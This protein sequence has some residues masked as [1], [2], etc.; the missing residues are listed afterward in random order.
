MKKRIMSMILALVLLICTIPVS[1]ANGG[2]EITVYLSLSKYGSVVESAEG[3]P[4][5]YV[6]VKLSDKDCYNLDDCFKMAHRE[7]YPDGEEGY[8][9]SVGDW[10]LGIDMLWGD[11]SYNFGYQVNRGTESVMGLDHQL[12]DGDFID[13]CIYQN[14]YPDTEGYSRFDEQVKNIFLGEEITLELT[15]ASG[16]DENWNTIYSV[17]DSADILINGEVTELATN[18]NGQIT[19]SFDEPGKYIVSAQK[20]KLLID[21]TVPAIT[22]PVCVVNVTHPATRLVHGIAKM[23]TESDLAALGGNLSWILADMAVYADLFPGSEN[24]LSGEKKQEAVHLLVD[25]AKEAET[26]GDLAKA[27]LAFRSLGYDPSKIYTET[28]EHIDVVEKL[29]TLVENGDVAVTNVYT[30]PYVIIALSQTETDL[31]ES[32]VSAA[33]LIKQEWQ[34]MS[35]GTDALTPMISALAPYA[36]SNLEVLTA[37]EESV[38]IVKGEQREDG[39]IDGFEGYEAASTAL[40]IW[41]LSETG[42]D[43]DAVICGEN[44]LIDGLLSVSSEENNGF[45]NA[46]ATEQGFRGLLAWHLLKNEI[47]RDLYDFSNCSEDE[48]NFT[49]VNYCPVR[50]DIS[51]YNAKIS[52]NGGEQMANHI[53]D[54]PAGEYRYEISA[55]GYY[56][57][58]GTFNI[59]EEDAD[60]HILKN[61]NVSLYKQTGGGSFVS[62]TDGKKDSGTTPQIQ[63]QPEITKPISISEIFADVSKDAWYNTAVKYVHEKGLFSGTD[64]GFE[65]DSPMTRAMLVTVLYRLDNAK[66]ESAELTFADVPKDAWYFESV[67]WAAQNGIVQGMTENAFMPDGNITREQLAVILYR[68]AVSQGI[69]TEIKNIS[70]ADTDDISDYAKDAVSFAVNSGIINGKGNNMLCPTDKAS[71]AEVATMMMRFAE[72]VNK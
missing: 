51:P 21:T 48:V 31:V 13:A 69:K 33:M 8:L 52:I 68:Y 30:L 40:A 23:Y 7:Y 9:S 11:T 35:F 29:V 25:F 65:P 49:G 39:L 46:F 36:D 19:L 26:P 66:N 61:I 34:D 50:F 5:A 67:I 64:K 18:E 15:Y 55:S 42:E 10:G 37:I 47:D 32:L 58:I 45:P 14:L 43:A 70:F 17:C 6:P 60:K 41:A 38:A 56:D 20:S 59:S 27:I 4:M 72:V 2:E 63:P 22:A 28:Y 3:E 24:Y 12:E 71:R 16:Y 44:S 53:F 1:F 54:L 62:N 57:E